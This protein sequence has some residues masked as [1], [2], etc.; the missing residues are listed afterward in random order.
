MRN[1]PIQ[2]QA[3]DPNAH[4]NPFYAP[5]EV[6]VGELYAALENPQALPE[7]RPLRRLPFAQHQPAQVVFQP[8]QAIANKELCYKREAGG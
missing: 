3:N 4:L 5:V 1:A 7:A 2:N 8:E 6:A